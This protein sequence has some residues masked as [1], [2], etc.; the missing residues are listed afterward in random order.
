MSQ[1]ELKIYYERIK[2]NFKWKLYARLYGV[3]AC[4]K[5][6]TKGTKTNGMAGQKEVTTKARTKFDFFFIAA[7][8]KS[9]L[10]VILPLYA[11]I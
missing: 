9:F 2:K 11:C 4:I 3:Y 10:I 5:R 8:A 6:D 7:L 1:H